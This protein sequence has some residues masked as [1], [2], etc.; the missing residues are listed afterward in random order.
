MVSNQGENIQHNVLN[1]EHCAVN[2]DL[3]EIS[4]SLDDLQDVPAPR[5]SGLRRFLMLTC[6]VAMWCGILTVS[7]VVGLIGYWVYKAYAHANGMG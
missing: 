3:R 5:E 1:I 4:Q 2:N 6:V 7:S